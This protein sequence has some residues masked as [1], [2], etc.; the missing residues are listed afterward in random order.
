MANLPTGKGNHLMDRWRRKKYVID[1]KL[2]YRLLAFNGVYFLVIVIA[3]AVALFTPL[4]NVLSSP[5]L[6]PR[7][8]GEAASKV[9]YIHATFWP[10]VLFLLLVLG[11]HSLL[12]SNKIA[13][14]L[15]RF[16]KIF[17]RIRD[18]DLS[19]TMKIRKG[20]Y[21][22]DE[23][24]RITEMMDSLREKVEKIQREQ[25]ELED[26]LKEIRRAWGDGMSEDAQ[27]RL[28]SL[29]EHHRRLKEEIAFFKTTR[30]PDSKD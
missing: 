19:S 20:D 13:G 27:A 11:A 4:M 25:R 2:Q 24:T 15:H 10:T 28:A 29:E 14:P 1:K 21:L 30:D 17:Q 22:L 23:Q 3:M 7:E 12:I 16:Q 5:D 18:G 6:S 9:L 8:Q 26:G